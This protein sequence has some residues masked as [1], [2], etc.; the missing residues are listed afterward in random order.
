MKWQKKA[1]KEGENLGAR[2]DL[3][4]T[5]FEVGKCLMEP[6]SKHKQLNDMDSQNCLNKARVMFEEMDLQYDLD[7]LDRLI[8]V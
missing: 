3:A 5:Y 1:I 6:Q 4:R 7:E 8:Y 2:P